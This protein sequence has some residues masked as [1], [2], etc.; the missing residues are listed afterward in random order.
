MNERS[1]VG[2][3]EREVDSPFLNGAYRFDSESN[4][5][6]EAVDQYHLLETPFLNSELSLI[7]EEKAQSPGPLA[8]LE[9]ELNEELDYDVVEGESPLDALSSS[10]LKAVRITSTF[11]TGWAGNFGGLTGNFDGQGI[12]FGL[13]NFAWKAGSL[14]ALLKEFLRDHP[15]AFAQVF[16]KDA[17]RFA[18]VVQATKTDPKNPKKRIRDLDR[19]MEFARGVNDGRNQ[20]R[21]PWKGYFGRLEADLDFRRIQVKAVRRAGDRARYWCRIFDLNTERA[22]AFMFDLVS[23][24]GGAWLNAA[25]FKGARRTLLN[26]ML[27]DKKVT[28]GHSALTEIEKME[29]IANM[30][31]DVSAQ[32]WQGKTREKIHRMVLARKL[33][34]V[35]GSGEVHGT[36][37]NLVRDFGVTDAP[38]NFDNDEREYEDPTEPRETEDREERPPD[39][40]SEEPEEYAAVE[41]SEEEEIESR[42]IAEPDAAALEG[43]EELDGANRLDAAVIVKRMNEY[44]PADGSAVVINMSEFKTGISGISNYKN[45]KANSAVKH[46][47]HKKPYRHPDAI[48]HIVL[49][50]TAADTGYGFDASNDYTAHLSV[51]RDATILQF[52]DLAE[53]EYHGNAMNKTAIG[54]EFVNRGWLSSTTKERG[55]GI[56][57]QESKLT[58]AQRIRYS[59][60]NGYLWAFWGNGFNVYR[61]PPSID[62]LEKEVELVGWLV[63]GLPAV[64]GSFGGISIYNLFPSI[65]D[66]WLQLTAYDQ[67]KDLW[68]FRKEDIPAESDR[69]SQNLFVMT[70]GYEFLEPSKIREKSGII[71]HNAFYAGHSDGSFLTLYTWLRLKKNK[72]KGRAFELCKSLM[73]DHHIR[74]S[75]RSH[76]DRKIYLLDVSDK[77]LV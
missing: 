53:L 72:D 24:H 71:S 5:G 52:N 65:D 17:D 33:W 74:V 55:E 19:Q 68:T 8:T 29:V 20:I 48:R 46:N 42:A 6:A 54:I 37:W 34:F 16:G 58:P 30:I 41:Q 13:M 1:S 61:L 77:N 23:S 70:T 35:K 11:E 36:S 27:K 2:D 51:L 50:E 60:S 63:N 14:V 18:D 56:P 32:A 25:K 15:S 59:E 49:H 40:E 57:G 75:L 28:V 66:T 47:R 21:E 26:A 39:E 62:Q 9:P 69:A 43:L 22:Y 45:W 38:P 3:S 4:A 7:T 73:K 67:V 31:A 12:S 76:G 64:L 44:D 10:E